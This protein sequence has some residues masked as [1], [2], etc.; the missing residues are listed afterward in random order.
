VSRFVLIGHPVGHSMSPA[1]HQ[2]AYRAFGERHEYVLVDAADESAVRRQVDELRAGRIVGANVTVPHKRLALALADELDESAQQVG[3]VNTLSLN[4][5]GS[6]LGS[7]TDAHG[8]AQAL[9]ALGTMGQRACVLGSGGA[10]LAAVVSCRLLGFDDVMVTA[11]RWQ[12]KEDP[13]S[14]PRAETFA[15][16]GARPMAWPGSNG[17]ETTRALAQVNLILQATSAGMKGAEDGE[18]LARL[19]PWSELGAQTV[20]YDLVYNPRETPFLRAAR[21]EGLTA[22]GGLSMLVLQAVRSIEI[23]LGKSAPFAELM[24]AAEQAL[25]ARQ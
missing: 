12:P 6:V 22:D 14:W 15:A 16:L 19:I 1:I 4:A 7:N 10:A 20:A 3:A 2:A 8:L 25:G 23:W 11:R 18:E 24:A 21:S 5:E 17:Q 9:R 13:T